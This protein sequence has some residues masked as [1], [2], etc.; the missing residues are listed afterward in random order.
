[1]MK[2]DTFCL[3][4]SMEFGSLCN[5]MWFEL[6]QEWRNEWKMI[7]QKYDTNFL[8]HIHRDRQILMQS[9]HFNFE[10]TNFTFVSLLFMCCTF[11]SVCHSFPSLSP[12][13]WSRSAL[14]NSHRASASISM[15][16]DKSINSFPRKKK[17]SGYTVEEEIKKFVA[18][19]YHIDIIETCS[20]ILH[21]KYAI[22]CIGS[23]HYTAGLTLKESEE[24][25]M[26]MCAVL[27]RWE[28][29][30]G[31]RLIGCTKYAL[32]SQKQLKQDGI[33]V[34]VCVCPT[35]A[36]CRTGQ[37]RSPLIASSFRLIHS[38]TL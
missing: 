27:C 37:F 38:L 23:I 16:D 7:T 11:M 22:Y 35:N 20:C 3:L 17:L 13:V 25:L 24:Y 26:V 2:T 29:R 1:M 36:V 6:S 14:G 31:F 28:R 10:I 9:R 33:N 15:A 21:F 34:C 8:R 12:S 32:P 19:S 4:S 18:C 5:A 30:M